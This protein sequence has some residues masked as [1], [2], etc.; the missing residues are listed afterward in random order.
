MFE[1]GNKFQHRTKRLKKKLQIK[2]T[3]SNIE[4]IKQLGRYTKPKYQKE[5]LYSKKKKMCKGHTIL[6]ERK[7]RV[8]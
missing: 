4:K 7:N 6:R 3:N 8:K 2:E 5:I 1:R